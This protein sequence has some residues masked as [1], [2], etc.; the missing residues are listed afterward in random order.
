MCYVGNTN[1]YAYIYVLVNVYV[2]IAVYLPCLGEIII[3]QTNKK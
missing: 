1:Y 2:A 3:H